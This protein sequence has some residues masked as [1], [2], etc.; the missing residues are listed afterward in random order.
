MVYDNLAKNIENGCAVQKPFLR[1]GRLVSL[2]LKRRAHLKRKLTLFQSLLQWRTFL[3][4][5]EEE[6]GDVGFVE[7]VGTAK[8]KETK[9]PLRFARGR[10]V[11]WSIRPIF[12]SDRLLESGL[13]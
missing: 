7:V 9:R 4:M 6:A 2:S 1:Q 11:G 10:G 3:T 12:P 13:K 8:S 5:C